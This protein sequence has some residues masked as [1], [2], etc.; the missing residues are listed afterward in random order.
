MEFDQLR[1]RS[2]RPLSGLLLLLL[3]ITLIVAML[4]QGTAEAVT[5]KF[6][7]KV[8]EGETLIYIS[9]LYGIDWQLI[10]EANKMTA[11]YL[12]APGQTLCIPEGTKPSNT[13]TSTTTSKNATL[14]VVP[15]QNEILVSVENFGKKTS[16][17]IR[18]WPADTNDSYRI[19]HFTTNKEGDFTGW[20]RMPYFLHRSPR[21]TLCVK[22]VWT[23]EASCVKY[24]DIFVYYPLVR[25]RCAGKSGR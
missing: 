8:Q 15:G 21:M 19:G 22:N 14:Q 2:K 9:Y 18:V 24:G 1:T 10:A 12:V 13:N 3:A 6:K 23:D 5:C 7:H 4:P 17:Y 11:P 16:Y 25:G 20:F